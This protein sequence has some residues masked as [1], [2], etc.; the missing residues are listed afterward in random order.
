METGVKVVPLFRQALRVSN[1]A[2]RQ[3]RDEGGCDVEVEKSPVE[4]W[5]TDS[6]MEV[7]DFW[8]EPSSDY[9]EL[10][11]VARSWFEL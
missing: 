9:G 11:T 8:K 5:R 2:S 6:L 3:S 7:A 1:K 4:F 10:V